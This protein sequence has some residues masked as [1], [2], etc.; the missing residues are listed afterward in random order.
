MLKN[1]NWNAYNIIYVHIYMLLVQYLAAQVGCYSELRIDFK[2]VVTRCLL[3]L[4]PLVVARSY[5][6]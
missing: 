5:S 4:A 6:V 1:S 2:Q 3:T